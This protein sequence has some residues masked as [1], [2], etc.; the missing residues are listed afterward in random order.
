M[1]L[2]TLGADWKGSPEAVPG[3]VGRIVPYDR[4]EELLQAKVDF[5]ACK[6]RAVFKAENGQS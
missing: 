4:R 2:A 5:L 3:D 1:K 6:E